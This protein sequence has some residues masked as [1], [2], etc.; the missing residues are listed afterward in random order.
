MHR[1]INVYTYTYKCA[2][3]HTQKWIY[4]CINLYTNREDTH[5]YKKKK[6]CYIFGYQNVWWL[7]KSR[8][9]FE[10]IEDI[11]MCF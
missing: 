7:L 9:V 11:S 1:H 3:R 6:I 4:V 2:Y 8:Y 10:D 5:T